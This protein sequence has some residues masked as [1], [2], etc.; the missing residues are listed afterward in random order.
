[1]NIKDSLKNKFAGKI[2][3]CFF[4]EENGYKFLRVEV[5]YKNMPDVLF[6]SK[7]I[8]SFI[9]EIDQS[10]KKYILDVYSSGAEIIIDIRDLKDYLNKNILINLNKEIKIKTSFEGQLLEIDNN[11]LKI[12]WNA[13]GQFR[14]QDINFEDIKNI[15]LSLK[16][17][18]G[19]QC[20]KN[21]K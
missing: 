13:K 8:S 3:D 18:K 16:V 12:R 20:Q 1:M 5:N 9:D 4:E 14:K 15:K 6:I 7:E 19:K 2:N 10:E 21:L 11:H 17:G